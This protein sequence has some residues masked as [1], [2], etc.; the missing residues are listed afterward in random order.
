MLLQQ[1]SFRSLLDGV[2]CLLACVTG[3]TRLCELKRVLRCL[4]SRVRP[5]L[6]S[7][8]F[9]ALGLVSPPLPTTVIDTGT[10]LSSG[11]S[12]WMIQ[13]SAPPPHVARVRVVHVHGGG[14][15][16]ADA[17][18]FRGY[19]S[20]LS[21]ALGGAEVWCP[22]YRLLPEHTVRDAVDDVLETLQ[23]VQAR[24]PALPVVCTA[25]SGGAIALLGA[26]QRRHPAAR[27]VERCVLLSPM[28]NT[29]FRA[30]ARPVEAGRGARVLRGVP[31]A[32]WWRDKST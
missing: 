15:V 28:V 16:S 9:P 17:W 27:A 1:L 32:I 24:R 8:R 4:T 26:F 31:S 29:R 30:P 22:N 14:M 5:Q 19:C 23:L 21:R 12:V 2:V 11:S 3:R 7:F 13:D 20:I 25:D 10:V 6:K 18:A